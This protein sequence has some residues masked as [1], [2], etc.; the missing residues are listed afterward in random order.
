MLLDGP[1]ASLRSC[2]ALAFACNECVV[3]G[4]SSAMHDELVTSAPTWSGSRGSR[5]VE[6]F[7]RTLSPLLLVLV[8]PAAVLLLW[9]AC[10]Y[11]DGSVRALFTAHGVSVI[12]HRFPRPSWA[13][14]EIILVFWTFE[15]LLLRLLP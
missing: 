12:V 7:R 13:A 10:T 11:L 3:L 1:S 2:E 6:A 14:A 9:I 15:L 8:T 5:A 4:L